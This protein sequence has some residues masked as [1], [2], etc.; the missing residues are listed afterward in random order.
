MSARYAVLLVTGVLLMASDEAW[1]QAAEAGPTGSTAPVLEPLLKE[2]GL[3]RIEITEPGEFFESNAHYVLTKDITAR[4]DALLFGKP[5]NRKIQNC[6]IDLN[7]HTVTYNTEDY[8]PTFREVCYGIRVFGPG[9]V[10]IRNGIIVQGKGR[11]AGCHG[12]NLYGALADVHDLTV[13]VYGAGCTNIS[14]A[15]GGEGGRIHDNYLENHATSIA[16]G[17]F[18]PTGI[19]MS[20]VGPHWEV[21]SNTIIGGHRSIDLRANAR[22]R[23]DTRAKIHH[24]RLAP[25]RTHGVKAPHA[26]LIYTAHQN[27]IYE[28]LIDAIDA[29]GI[30]VQ[31]GSKDNHVHH[32]LVAARYSTAAD[33]RK[34]GYIENRCYG[35]WER[36]GG[37]SGNKVTNNIFIV[38]NATKGDATSNTIG[39]IVG[40]GVNYPEPLLTAEITNN[41]VLCWHDDPKR[42]VTGIM[43]KHCGS[44][45][46][47]SGNRILARS[48]G[49]N[50]WAKSG[51]VKIANNAVLRPTNA[52][53]GWKALGGE[54]LRKCPSVGNRSLRLRRDRKRPATPTGL[55]AIER[56]GAVELRWKRNTESDLLGY[57]VYRNG[58]PLKMPL[59]GAPFWVDLSVKPGVANTYAIS[60][61]DLSG[62]ESRS[63]SPVTIT[64]ADR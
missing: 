44:G 40:T 11:N 48:V 25:R 35:Y 29:R 6:I 31:M 60:A 54:D 50:V 32:N 24:N 15:G 23:H 12:I 7:G 41:V 20:Y 34:G 21:Y 38:N 9:P 13:K 26:I 1:P 14:R 30:N 4:R 16:A 2:E 28:N 63:C 19:S 18:S 33:A 36:S 61:V 52:D 53:A 57:R 8:N 10:E 55:K 56:P 59:R 3:K 43:L 39:L 49:I 47:V 5:W 46:K 42:S 62:N 51:G 17:L 37:R 27:E 22:A 58:K 64:M 45:V